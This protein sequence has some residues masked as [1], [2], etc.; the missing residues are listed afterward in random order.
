MNI[1]ILN[2]YG[3]EVNIVTD[4]ELS[5]EDLDV[6]SHLNLKYPMG[7]LGIIRI[8]FDKVLP[9]GAILKHVETDEKFRNITA[10][11]NK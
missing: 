4:T 11:V 10:T 8:Y 9:S 3:N 2:I 5:K 6:I 1:K 7:V